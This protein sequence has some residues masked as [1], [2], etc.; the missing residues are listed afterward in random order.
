MFSFRHPP[1]AINCAL[2][3]VG[4]PCSYS[5]YN[6]PKKSL[7]A[8]RFRSTRLT[9]PRV[10]VCVRV[11]CLYSSKCTCTF[12]ST[13]LDIVVAFFS[14]RFIELCARAARCKKQHIDVI[15]NTCSLLLLSFAVQ[16]ECNA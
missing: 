9:Q 3:Q 14:L 6:T 7:L 5:T 12:E 16:E 1:I 8:Q 13:L 15:V 2:I 11:Y 10:N 4:T